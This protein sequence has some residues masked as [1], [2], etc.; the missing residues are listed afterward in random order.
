[1]KRLFALLA[2][3]AFS[4]PVAL[5]AQG[6][7]GIWYSL[8]AQKKFNSHWSAA[9]EGEFR[10]RNDARTAD[11]WSL[12]LSASYK[13]NGF[14]KATAGYVFLDDNN[15]E[16]ITYNGD[17][18]NKWTPSYW[19]IRH[20]FFVALTGQVKW[21]RLTF[22]LRERW[23]YTYRPET[24]TDRW[25]FDDAAWE[26]RTVSEKGKNVLRSRLQVEYNIPKCKFEPYASVELFNAWALDKTRF[27]IG[28]DYKLAKKH[29]FQVFYRYQRVNGNDDGQTNQHVL[30]L[31]Y[32]FKF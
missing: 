23:Q 5:L 18:L 13:F 11:R 2:L 28:S 32:Q 20:R 27:S 22:S 16:R 30:G 10:S 7:F 6:D 9:V 25:D 26:T 17:E 3:V 24:T 12:G 8:G 14:L 15:H 29:A 19:G 4:C 21:N 31:G 1:M